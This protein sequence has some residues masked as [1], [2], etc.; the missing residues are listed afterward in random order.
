MPDPFHTFCFRDPV[1]SVML[2][3]K[4]EQGFSVSTSVEG[5]GPKRYSLPPLQVSGQGARHVGKP[6][7]FLPSINAR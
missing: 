4:R 2:M 3:Q 7:P 5:A 1:H 6:L